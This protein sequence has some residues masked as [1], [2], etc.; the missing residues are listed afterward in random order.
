[1]STEEVKTQSPEPKVPNKRGRKPKN[2][3]DDDIKKQLL[4]NRACANKFA[5]LLYYRNKFDTKEK[6]EQKLDKM[7]KVISILE[8]LKKEH[9]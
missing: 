2:K 7:N 6:I 4:K 3:T 5:T 1:M 8:E 9:K